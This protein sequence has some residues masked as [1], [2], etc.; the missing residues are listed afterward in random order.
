MS[1]PKA[2]CPVCGYG[3]NF[4]PWEGSSPSDEICPCCGIQFGLE[5]IDAENEAQFIE[6]YE[7]IRKDWLKAGSKW[8]SPKGPPKE[9][10]AETQLKRY[11][12]NESKI[13]HIRKKK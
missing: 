7:S 3:L 13:M 12:E 4:L 5:D 11:L 2:N 8:F 10:N 9:W 1:N 6:I